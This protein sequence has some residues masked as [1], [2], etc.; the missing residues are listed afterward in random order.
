MEATEHAHANEVAAMK[1]RLSDVSAELATLEAQHAAAQQA[2]SER[3]ATQA[4]A[5]AAL[6]EQLHKSREMLTYVEEAA[7]A[8][9]QADAAGSA[10]LAAAREELA[11]LRLETEGLRS[12]LHAKEDELQQQAAQADTWE[13]E[14]LGRAC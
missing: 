11:A 13:S 8:S 12:T 10:A 2:S 9:L 3:D 6:Q 4:S 5:I 14:C 1:T 7:E